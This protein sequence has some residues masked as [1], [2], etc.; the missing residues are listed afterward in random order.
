[1]RRDLMMMSGIFAA[2]LGFGACQP[3][4]PETAKKLDEIS[5][6]LDDLDKKLASNAQPRPMMPQGPDPMAVYAVPIEGA[7]TKGP[8]AAKITIVEAFEFA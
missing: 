2:G 7:P 3:H 5:K 4:N 1:M 8:K 6:K